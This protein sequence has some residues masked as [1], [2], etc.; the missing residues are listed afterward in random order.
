MEKPIKFLS[1]W[2]CLICIIVFVIQLLIPDFTDLFYLSENAWKMPW[3]FITAVFLHGSI[4]HLLYNLFALFLFGIIL[5]KLIG[6]KKFFWLFLFSG[7]FA[8]II[9]FFWFPNALGASGAIM[10][11]LGTLAVLRPM[12]VVWAFN[13]PMPMFILA[14]IW[15][16]GSV[17]GLFGFGD[18]GVGHL[19]HLSGIFLGILY[20]LFLRLKHKTQKENSIIFERKIL[21]PEEDMRKWEDF[22][23]KR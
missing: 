8:N 15:V 12:M 2:F 22:Y 20:G 18:S 10:A 7:L 1:L 13:M 3:Q 14:I 9:S 4:T 17:L 6:S 5:E 23:I 19:A 21:I 16:A 11:V